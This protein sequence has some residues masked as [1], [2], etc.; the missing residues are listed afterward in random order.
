MKSNQLLCRLALF[1]TLMAAAAPLAAQDHIPWITDLKQARDLAE[2]QNRLV[3]LHFWSES[4]GPC[5]RLEQHVFNQPEFIRS[6]TTG[7]IPAKINVDQHPH[8]A[9]H[10]SI[11]A[12]PTDIIVT[13]SGREIQR[14]TS[15]QDTNQY[16]AMLDGIRARASVSGYMPLGDA[17]ATVAANP[18]PQGSATA[19]ASLG[20]TAPT[21]NEGSAT[22]PPANRYESRYSNPL[23]QQAPPQQQP[24][25]GR[26]ANPYGQ[27]EGNQTAD[28]GSRWDDL[29]DSGGP[30]TEP[31][32]PTLNPYVSES[33]AAPQQPQNPVANNPYSG[34]QLANNHPPNNHPP[35]NQPPNN[36][37]AQNQFAQNP[38]P[39]QPPRNNTAPARDPQRN[40]G[41]VVAQHANHAPQQSNNQPSGKPTVAL[42]GYC[43][44][45]LVHQRGWLQGEK[46]WGAIH[47]GHIYLFAGPQ[48]QQQFLANPELYAPL[49][50]GHD[51]VRFAETGKLVPGK[52]EYGL[53]VDDPGPIALFSD[54]A[55]LQRFHGNSS[56]YFNVIRQAAQQRAGQQHRQR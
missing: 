40:T 44:V 16:I 4:C 34:D 21:L 19:D 15:K 41:G 20:Q 52:R 37:P 45:T 26:Y 47:E 2:R 23:Q 24:I 53:Y 39:Q 51:P 50:G 22:A 1:A 31:A 36:Q 30:T 32:K 55:S 5:K 48:Q 11:E 46:Q 54:E 43:P 3:L 7:Y 18:Y 28:S 25:A 10:Y 35:N 42:D 12:V 14:F 29:R 38:Q 6:L 56:H 27:P 17:G 8:I 49:L 33:P 13:P 9:K